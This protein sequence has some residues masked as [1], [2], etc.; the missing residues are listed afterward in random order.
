MANGKDDRLGKVALGITGLAL[1]TGALAAGYAL[2]NTKAR[3]ALKKRIGKTVKGFNRVREVLGE[4]NIYQAVQHRI[5]RSR[6]GRNKKQS[7]RDMGQAVLHQISEGGGD[8][9]KSKRGRKREFIV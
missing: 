1:A 9:K 5:G 3:T 2:T 8:K 4:G 6:K 7:S